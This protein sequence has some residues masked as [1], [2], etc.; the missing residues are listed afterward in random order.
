MIV[1]D[2]NRRP[3]PDLRHLNADVAVFAGVLEYVRDLPAVAAWLSQQTS[4]TVASYDHV[5][6]KP[7]TV[8]RIVELCRR[9]YFGYHNDYTLEQLTAIFSSAG[10]RCVES[11]AW[12]SQRIMVFA[13]ATSQVLPSSLE[14]V[15][16]PNTR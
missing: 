15:R 4:M 5:Q 6:S 16:H 7:A 12:D 8:A 3:L 14:P 9:R 2:L 10:F 13:S 11:D 1:C